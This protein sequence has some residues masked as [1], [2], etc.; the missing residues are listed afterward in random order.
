MSKNWP[1]IKEMLIVQEA[2]AQF[3]QRSVAKLGGHYFYF[4][5]I[6]NSSK[7]GGL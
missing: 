3:M 4:F 7:V 5:E 6:E 2:L 1:K